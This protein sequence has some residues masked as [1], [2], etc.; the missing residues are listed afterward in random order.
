ME[1]GGGHGL[2]E[3]CGIEVRNIQVGYKTEMVE[4]SGGECYETRDVKLRDFNRQ[5]V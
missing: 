1:R 4:N 5:H 3:S 2:R